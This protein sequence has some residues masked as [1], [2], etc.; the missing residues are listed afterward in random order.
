MYLLRYLVYIFH[1]FEIYVF[2]FLQ[3]KIRTFLQID[4]KSRRARC[5]FY[6][7]ILTFLVPGKKRVKRMAHSLL[8]DESRMT[9]RNI[10]KLEET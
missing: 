10:K 6:F 4:H 8:S 2:F 7:L 3:T 1:L 5:I 9:I